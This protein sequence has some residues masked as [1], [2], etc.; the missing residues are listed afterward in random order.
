[1]K[2][3]EI[4][5][6]IERKSKVFARL[7]SNGK[8]FISKAGVEFIGLTQDNTLKFFIDEDDT[9]N[10]YIY[11][12]TCSKDIINSCKIIDGY[13]LG[14]TLMVGN[15]FKFMDLTKDKVCYFNIFKVED[16]NNL[17]QFKIISEKT[18]NLFP[19]L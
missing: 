2:L 13:S 19:S 14:I 17:F 15:S 11:G 3:K 12:S 10:K 8:L 18:K 9:E 5:I 1:M 6:T 4:Q 7:Y 16:S